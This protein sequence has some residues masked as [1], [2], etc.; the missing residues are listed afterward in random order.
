MCLHSPCL[1][2]YQHILIRKSLFRQ[3]LTTC[4]NAHTLTCSAP[5][6]IRTKLA[7]SSKL[8]RHSTHHISNIIMP[9]LFSLSMQTL[10]QAS[11]KRR[12]R[13]WRITHMFPSNNSWNP[14]TPT[15]WDTPPL[16][17]SPSTTS[18]SSAGQLFHP[19]VLQIPVSL[20]THYRQ[21]FSFLSY[22]DHH[23]LPF[24]PFQIQIQRHVP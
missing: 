23:P 24:F 22:S 4:K 9:S 7:A 15:P 20:F 18:T 10:T 6:S 12:N 1:Q 19:Q 11:T 3:T 2:L 21:Q 17:M 14:S 8:M 16:F 13:S 5:L